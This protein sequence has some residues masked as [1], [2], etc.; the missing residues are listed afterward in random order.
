MC[1]CMQSEFTVFLKK[2]QNLLN[3]INNDPVTGLAIIRSCN[4]SVSLEIHLSRLG[5]NESVIVYQSSS[6]I[7]QLLDQ[8]NIN[9]INFSLY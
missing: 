6:C 1:S 5:H 4:F 3:R 7:K 2:N 8:Y 9:F